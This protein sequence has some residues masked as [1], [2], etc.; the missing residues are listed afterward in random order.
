[1]DY[2][3]AEPGRRFHCTHFAAFV[4]AAMPVFAPQLPV[5]SEEY[6]ELVHVFEAVR[7]Y[8][9]RVSSAFFEAS[10]HGKKQAPLPRKFRFVEVGARYGPWGF[11]AM[12]ALR[13]MEANRGRGSGGEK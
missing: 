7:E 3:Q 8:A 9:E 10:E 12:Q 1:M 2:F 5:I 6:V 11:R 13:Q 4:D